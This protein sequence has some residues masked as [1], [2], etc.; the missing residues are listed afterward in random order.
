MKR[1][2]K[3]VASTPAWSR[4]E[5][6]LD[7]AMRRSRP[8]LVEGRR[9]RA[10]SVRLRRTSASRTTAPCASVLHRS[11]ARAR[12]DR[13]RRRRRPQRILRAAQ[14]GGL[15]PIVPSAGASIV[16]RRRTCRARRSPPV[17]R[18]PA[19]SRRSV[20]LAAL[21]RP[22]LEARR[23]GS[24]LARSP[25]CPT[26][27]RPPPRS[28]RSRRSPRGGARS[29][30]CERGRIARRAAASCAHR[31]AADRAATRATRACL[32]RQIFARCPSAERSTPLV[33]T[34]S[35]G[36]DRDL[37]RHDAPPV[38]RLRSTLRRVAPRRRE[39]KSDRAAERLGD[40]LHLELDP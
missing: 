29:A 4:C 40:L 10:S 3:I 18:C 39:H 22:T 38:T 16:G 1:R 32:V 9:A 15:G 34:S 24:A 36:A 37:V 6:D 11:G 14:E 28:L 31:R 7:A 30:R 12:V 2:R 13:A 35:R 21:R 17:R 33:S 25:S 27:S 19:A 26:R 20:A 23:A 5:Q 8:A